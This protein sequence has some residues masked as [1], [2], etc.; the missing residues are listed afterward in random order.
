MKKL[1]M[2]LITALLLMSCSNPFSADMQSRDFVE[3]VGKVS[4]KGAPLKGCAVEIHIIEKVY[5]PTFG[6]IKDCYT[7]TRSDTTDRK[8]WYRIEVGRRF[9]PLWSKCHLRCRS[10][11]CYDDY[12]ECGRKARGVWESKV[13]KRTFPECWDRVIILATWKQKKEKKWID[14]HSIGEWSSLKRGTQTKREFERKWGLPRI[15]THPPE[16]ITMIPVVEGS[17]RTDFDW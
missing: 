1:A 11:S 3:F 5:D 14:E 4:V 6:T 7:L 8:G 16:S 9:E 2:L 17:I 15:D 13:D 12:Y 10:G